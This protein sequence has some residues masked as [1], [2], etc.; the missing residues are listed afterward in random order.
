MVQ[1]LP[2][3]LARSPWRMIGRISARS[4]DAFSIAVFT[5]ARSGSSVE[6]ALGL[7]CAQ[8]LQLITIG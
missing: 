3:E 1:G 8:P 2:R 6:D 4:S 5:G 7:V